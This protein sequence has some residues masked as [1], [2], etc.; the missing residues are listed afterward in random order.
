MLC[1]I[2]TSQFATDGLCLRDW[3]SVSAVSV[4]ATYATSVVKKAPLPLWERGLG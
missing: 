1:L 3:R 2:A 4:Y